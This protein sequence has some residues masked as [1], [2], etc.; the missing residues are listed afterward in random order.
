MGGDRSLH[1]SPAQ[2]RLIRERLHMSQAEF[3]RV[4]GLARGTVSQWENGRS[5]INSVSASFFGHLNCTL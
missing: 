5:P 2:A 1:Y 4:Y 3:A